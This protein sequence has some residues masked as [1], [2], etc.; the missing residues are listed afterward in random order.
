MTPNDPN[1]QLWD[2]VRKDMSK[3]QDKS[4][5]NII[6]ERR[7]LM[8]VDGKPEKRHEPKSKYGMPKRS[9]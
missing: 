9:K 7:R 8:P 6:D 4:P 5:F 1:K 2:A 3:K